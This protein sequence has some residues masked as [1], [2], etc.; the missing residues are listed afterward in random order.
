[1]LDNHP[2]YSANIWFVGSE[3]WGTGPA[4]SA[5]QEAFIK[6]TLDLCNGMECFDV[7][8]KVYCLKKKKG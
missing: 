3:G 2:K 6:D 1:M 7:H 4:S 5:V 8:L